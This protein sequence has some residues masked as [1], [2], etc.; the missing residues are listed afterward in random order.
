MLRRCRV[1]VRAAAAAY[2][3]PS[4]SRSISFSRAVCAQLRFRDVT[5]RTQTPSQRERVPTGF[6]T[7]LG[8]RRTADGVQFTDEMLE[9]LRWLTQKHALRQDVL[10]LGGSG[11][12]RRRLAMAFCELLKLETEYVC[13]SRDTTD[14]DLK[15]RREIVRGTSVFVDQAPVRAAIHVGTSPVAAPT[16]VTLTSA[17]SRWCGVRTRRVAS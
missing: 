15:Q 10:L 9:H 2:V 8:G 5:A 11:A 13:I 7:V 12:A 17:L 4:S 1:V 6:A 14:S 3:S 16:L